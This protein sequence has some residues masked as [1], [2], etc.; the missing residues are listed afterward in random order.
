MRGVFLNGRDD[1]PKSTPCPHRVSAGAQFLQCRPQAAARR[2][3]PRRPRGG[4]RPTPQVCQRSRRRASA[5]MTAFATSA[6]TSPPNSSRSCRVELFGQPQD[7]RRERFANARFEQRIDAWP[8]QLEYLRRDG[9]SGIVRRL[10][11]RLHRHRVGRQRGGSGVNQRRPRPARR[12]PRSASAT[13]RAAC[14]SGNPRAHD[15]ATRV[16]CTRATSGR[17]A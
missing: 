15:P 17:A 9:R 5:S 12:S 11:Q 13:A 3:P 16:W 6:R 1:T 2:P 14:S 8:Q 4:E 7:L 10:R